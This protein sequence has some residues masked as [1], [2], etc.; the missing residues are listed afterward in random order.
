MPGRPE[1]DLVTGSENEVR[2]RSGYPR[3]RLYTSA[4]G[5]HSWLEDATDEHPALVR[6]MIRCGEQRTGLDILGITVGRRVE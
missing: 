6:K 3:A 5:V 1:V 4:A 2:T